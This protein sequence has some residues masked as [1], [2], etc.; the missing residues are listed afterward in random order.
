MWVNN[1]IP[2]SYLS[3]FFELL[4]AASQVFLWLAFQKKSY[5][6]MHHLAI[7]RTLEA[8]I[9]E[10]VSM[11]ESHVLNFECDHG[12]FQN[13]IYR[14]CANV[15]H[16]DIVLPRSRNN[17][18]THMTVFLQQFWWQQ[19]IHFLSQELNYKLLALLLCHFLSLSIRNYY[20]AICSS[21]CWSKLNKKLINMWAKNGHEI[22]INYLLPL[23]SSFKIT[24]FFWHF[25]K[26][27][28]PLDSL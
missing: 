4:H 5:C 7:I 8:R 20:H 27:P 24:H 10:N 6:P 28:A 9:E 17:V 15:S 25:N 11:H 3:G 14:I 1:S 19:D 13:S 16:I 22:P 12:H 18:M 21:H 23:F 2:K 26:T